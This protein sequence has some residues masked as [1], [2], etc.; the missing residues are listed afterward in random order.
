MDALAAADTFLVINDR[1]AVF[2][3]GKGTYRTAGLAGSLQIN[4]G[5]VGAGLGALPA[6]LTLIGI[7]AGSPFA[8]LDGAEAAGLDTRLA[9]AV[10]TVISY[11]KTGDGAVC[12]CRLNDLNDIGI[13]FLTG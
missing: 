6:F 8:R 2:I 12:A 1:Q 7:D 13:V 5:I 11:G 10:L 3:I 9:D 4:Y